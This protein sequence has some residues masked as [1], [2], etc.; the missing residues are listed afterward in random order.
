MYVC[1]TSETDLLVLD[2]YHSIFRLQAFDG[3]DSGLSRTFMTGD[4]INKEFEEFSMKMVHSTVKPDIGVHY[5][6]TAGLD[7]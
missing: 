6:E 5:Y 3:P 1:G 4:R 2:A 7:I